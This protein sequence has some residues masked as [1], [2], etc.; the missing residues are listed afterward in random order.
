MADGALVVAA[1][2]ARAVHWVELAVCGEVDPALFFPDENSQAAAA[3]A[4]CR[5]CEV[6]PQCLE[7]A[8][9]HFETGVWGGFTEKA[10]E[11]MNRRRRD[12]E[13]AGDIIAAD[14]AAF[15]ARAERSAVLAGAV[16]E[17]KR[18]RERARS[19]A[20][21]AAIAGLERAS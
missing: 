20:A 10:R 12:G 4:V 6:R 3:R 21:R 5:S 17:R 13:T 1:M 18:G 19:A 2:S 16:A 7:H 11:G 8:L 9:D 14:D 15:Y